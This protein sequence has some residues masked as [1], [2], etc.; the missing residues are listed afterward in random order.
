M[1]Q[2]CSNQLTLSCNS[3][4]LSLKATRISV[5]SFCLT[6]LALSGI[7]LPDVKPQTKVTFVRLPMNLHR[8][9]AALAKEDRRTVSN[10]ITVL[11]QEA[12][13]RH[14]LPVAK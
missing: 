6:P 10:M 9:V 12:I 2:A 11:I 8:Q 13:D 7:L 1:I 3:F 4:V 5:A 14:T